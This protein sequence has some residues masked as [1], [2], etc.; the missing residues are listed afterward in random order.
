M[1]KLL[2]IVLA[3]L[4]AF[5]M[6]AVAYAG[7]TTTISTTVPDAT[8]TLNIPADQTIEFGDTSHNIGDVSITN[9]SGFAEGKNLAVTIIYDS[10]SSADTTTVIPYKINRYTG[11]GY[12][13]VHVASGSQ[14]TFKGYA[15]GAVST[16]PETLIML[17]ESANWGK[18]LGGHYST[19]ITFT[20]EVVVED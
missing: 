6:T 12:A 9:S 1:K 16:S 11:Q 18:A 3:I 8:Y 19:T 20:A 17:I 7:N 14:L 15:T 2:A 5:S 10:F 4:S 13:G